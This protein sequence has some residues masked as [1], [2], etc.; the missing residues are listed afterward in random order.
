MSMVCA[1]HE[2]GAAFYL[3]VLISPVKAELAVSHAY[4]ILYKY[5][6]CYWAAERERELI[7][8]MGYHQ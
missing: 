5:Y 3:L 4:S 1:G 2:T 6:T 7:K 8:E